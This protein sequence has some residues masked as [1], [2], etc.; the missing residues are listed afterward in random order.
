MVSGADT[1][2]WSKIDGDLRKSARLFLHGTK[3]DVTT[4]VPPFTADMVEHR[5]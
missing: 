1:H 4:S 5:H 2:P 3:F